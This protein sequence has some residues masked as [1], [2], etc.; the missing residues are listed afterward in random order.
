MKKRNAKKGKKTPASPSTL[1]C[2]RK[3]LCGSAML[4]VLEIWEPNEGGRV[5][6][7]EKIQT[8]GMVSVAVRLSLCVACF[9]R[10]ESFYV[11]DGWSFSTT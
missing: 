4:D 1:F 6:Q 5:R 3:C 11:F 7:S 9:A 2:S 10:G 8:I